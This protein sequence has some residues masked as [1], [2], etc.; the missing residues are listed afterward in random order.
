[1]CGP[2]DKVSVSL[3][4]YGD[5]LD[6][7][8]VTAMLG[9]SPSQSWR[10]GDVLDS[11][12]Q[13]PERTG[14]WLLKHGLSD[15]QTLSDQISALLDLVTS[16]LQVWQKLGARHRLRVFCM[17]TL[18]DWNRECGIPASLLRRLGERGLDLDF[19]IYAD[20]E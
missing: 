15:S 17:L 4:V 16:D 9:V 18:L 20:E 3:G 19:D 13:V 7:S 6:P 1:M 14:V 10:K 11:S 2:V 5:D 8:T 12:R